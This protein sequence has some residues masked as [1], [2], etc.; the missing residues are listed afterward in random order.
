MPVTTTY[1]SSFEGTPSR[2]ILE[3]GWI[4]ERLQAYAQLPT[5]PAA[6][7]PLLDVM[8]NMQIVIP[9]S[10]SISRMFLGAVG[11]IFCGAVTMASAGCLKVG[12]AVNEDQTAGVAALGAATRNPDYTPLVATS[13]PVGSQILP[14]LKPGVLV[15]VTT[16][17]SPIL[18]GSSLITA[19]GVAVNMSS[20]SAS[21]PA[22]V[23]VSFLTLLRDTSRPS[24]GEWQILPRTIKE[25]LMTP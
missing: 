10:S 2:T 21:R 9:S 7:V 19:S 6:S 18:L 24:F 8:T 12:T 5:T 22:I 3:Q 20:A 14:A 17:W 23:L 1:P 25:L 16:N 13:L 4:L 15:E 11:G